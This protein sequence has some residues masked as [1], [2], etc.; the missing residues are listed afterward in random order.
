MVIKVIKVEKKVNKSAIFSKLGER[1]LHPKLAPGQNSKHSLLYTPG[2][3][4]YNN[5][6]P[7]EISLKQKRAN[8]HLSPG[9]QPETAKKSKDKLNSKRYKAIVESYK[10]SFRKDKELIARSTSLNMISNNQTSLT[11]MP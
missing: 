9:F 7:E 10:N 1:R 8:L 2:P 11:M 4:A 3:E 6:H 5:N